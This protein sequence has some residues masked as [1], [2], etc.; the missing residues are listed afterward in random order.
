MA[1][2]RMRRTLLLALPALAL[3]ACARDYSRMPKAD[4][5]YISKKDR[6]LFMLRGREVIADYP[7]RLGFAPDGTKLAEGD[8]RTPEGLYH[9]DRKNP[10]SKFYLSVGIDYPNAYDVARAEAMGVNPGGDIFIHGQ[11]NG[12]W[13]ENPEDWT[14]GCIAVANRAIEEIYARVPI[15]TPVMIQA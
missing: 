9:V 15:G 2:S 5:V 11:P 13:R 3:G 6:R 4:Q 7:I 14:A 1:T 8:G 10:R 12:K